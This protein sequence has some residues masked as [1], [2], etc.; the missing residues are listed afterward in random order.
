M[1]Y[2]VYVLTDPSTN[3]VMYVGITGNPNFRLSRHLDEK[4]GNE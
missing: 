1:L 4:K 3:V 2:F